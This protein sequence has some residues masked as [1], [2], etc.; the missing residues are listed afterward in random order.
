MAV[1]ECG[2]LDEQKRGRMRSIQ[3]RRSAVL[4]A[5]ASLVAGLLVTLGAVPAQADE[6][7]DGGTYVSLTGGK[8]LDTRTGI[9][10]PK[11]AVG[12]AKSVTFPVAG[13]LGV[14]TNARSVFV[15]LTSVGA[16]S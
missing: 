8:V 4:L 11:A 2:L 14:P 9:G 16:T 6:T 1:D 15:T 3:A 12:A 7:I 10:A 5:L 13:V